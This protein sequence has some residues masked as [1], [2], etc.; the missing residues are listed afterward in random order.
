MPAAGFG[1]GEP[2]VLV[3]LEMPAA[4]VHEMVVTAADRDQ[5]DQIRRSAM[6]PPHDV[7]DLAVV[8]VDVAARDAT[9]P[10]ERPESSALGSVGQ[11]GGAPEVQFSGRVEHDAVADDDGVD[12]GGAGEVGEHAGGDLDREPPVH[13]RLGRRISRRFDD[14]LREIRGRRISIVCLA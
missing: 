10:V 2:T 7:V 4:F 9:G 6:T 11:P 12:V 13:D 5:V 8:E 14:I 1:D 3:E